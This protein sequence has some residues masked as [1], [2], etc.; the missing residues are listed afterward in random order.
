MITFAVHAARRLL[1][2]LR[3]SVLAEGGWQGSR[4]GALLFPG[5]WLPS[6][7][8]VEQMVAR[9]VHNPEAAGS[10]PARATIKA[11]RKEPKGIG[12]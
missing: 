11:I 2:T 8:A 1:V 6:C 9:W 12:G 4:K 5:G 10:S 7:R 3:R